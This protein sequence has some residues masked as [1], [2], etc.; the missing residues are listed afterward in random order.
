DT[1]ELPG[2]CNSKL[3]AGIAALESRW[4]R[5]IEQLQ[6]GERLQLEEIARHRAH[7][8][9]KRRAHIGDRPRE[10]DFGPAISRGFLFGDSGVGK[11]WLFRRV[12]VN[13]LFDTR[14]MALA[15]FVGFARHT[16]KR[17]G[18]LLS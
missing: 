12:Q 13:N 14:G 11:R 6:T 9:R 10:S 15:Q 1:T 16:R 4:K 3:R 2:A 5:H 8:V 18:G 7:H 17:S